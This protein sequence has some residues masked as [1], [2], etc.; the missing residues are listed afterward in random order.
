MKS[1]NLRHQ[2]KETRE[3]YKNMGIVTYASL[4][5]NNWYEDVERE[6]DIEDPRFWCMEQI[7]IYKDIYESM[8]KVRPMQAT[9]V[10]LLSQNYHFEDAIWVTERMGLHKLMK[11]QLDSSIPLI[12][13]FY[14]TLVLK[15]DEDRTM[16]WMSGSTPCEASFHKFARLLGYRF[17]GGHRLH[18]PQRTDKDVLYDLYDQNGAVGTTTG[19]LPIYGQLLRVFRTTIAPS[20][21]N[22]DALRGALVDLLRL[23]FDCAQDG[24]ET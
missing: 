18:G 8:K 12:K 19:L 15:K 16:Q 7:F 20:G 9:Y 3:N 6:L 17:E 11:V 24:D 5:R 13:Q 23:A 10:E 1:A 21:G 22:N 14:A 2:G 4:R